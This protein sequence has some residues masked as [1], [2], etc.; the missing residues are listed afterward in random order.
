M[1]F[2]AA[3]AVA[4]PAALGSQTP[5][6][7][8]YEVAF[9]NAVHHEA[10]VRVE[11]TGVPAGTLALRMS[12]SSPGR[13]ALHEFAKNVYGVQ[14]V[15]GAGRSLRIARPTPHQWNVTTT[16]GTVRV[17]Y[18]LFGDRVD[19]TYTGISEAHAHLNMPATFLWAR[20]FETR[21]V[22]VTFRPRPG[23]RIATQLVPTADS[24]TYTAPHLA[25]FMDSPTMLGPTIVR[26]WPVTQSGRTAQI[27]LAL[28]HL[29]TDAEADAF[30]DG[31]QRI[32]REAVN[33]WGELPAFDFGAYTFLAAFLPWAADD[34]MEHRNSTSLTSPSTLAGD[35]PGLLNT[36][37]HEFMHA[38]N[39]ERLRP[40]AIEPFDLTD[41]NP[42]PDL[43]L[44]EGVSWYYNPL[45]L[46]RAGLLPVPGFLQSAGATIDAVVNAPGRRWFSLAEMS[47]QAPLI[48]AAT[49]VDPTNRDNTYLSYYTW[50]AAVGL[51]LDLALR[52][53]HDTLSLDAYLRAMWNE[54]GRAQVN[55]APTKPYRMDDARRVLGRV[56]GDTAWANDFFA[57]FVEGR[58]VPDFA[59]LAAPAG[60]VV[61]RARPGRA[62]MG[63]VQLQAEGTKVRV[64]TP[65]LQ[66]TPLYAVGVDAGDRIAQLDGTAIN[67]VSQVDSLL[68]AHRPGD[69]VP[70]VFIGRA[71][72]REAVVTLAE[73]PHLEAVL[74]ETTGATPSPAQ[75]AFRH[76][77]L[78]STRK[79]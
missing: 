67:R 25:Y 56:A 53:R 17:E 59:A 57:R 69:R 46:T 54:F 38:W 58:A 43:W 14:A 63:D 65:T 48:D 41:A 3:L 8:R 35:L 64:A 7:V 5:P 40:R 19:G 31:L 22:R 71:G 29:G 79:D 77:W 49:S 74:L 55:Y 27:R 60:V 62:W 78:A 61:R 52:A 33:V 39:V 26:S 30:A 15:D 50:G 6:A 66:G 4:L 42:S 9:P 23:W 10:V 76:R 1:R 36:A 21:P 16:G 32:V 18:T 47:A 68:A 44:A 70:L 13:Y 11:F 24:L 75:L 20:G 37:A 2:V 72:P 51:G 73:D 12:R 45:L 34:G 28:H